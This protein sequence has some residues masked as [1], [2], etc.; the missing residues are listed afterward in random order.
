MDPLTLLAA[1]TILTAGTQLYSGWQEAQAYK[2]QQA[3]LNAQADQIMSTAEYNAKLMGVEARK[4]AGQQRVAAAGSGVD[5]SSIS[6]QISETYFNNAQNVI[7]YLSNARQ[8]ATLTRMNAATAGKTA[9]QSLLSAGIGATSTGLR[10]AYEFSQYAPS[11]QGNRR[12]TTRST[13]IQQNS[14][15]PVFSLS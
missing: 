15:S 4:L 12:Q 7:S 5:V 8:Q 2:K 11:S 1:S 14:S 13:E 3:F 10:G 9:T 6:D